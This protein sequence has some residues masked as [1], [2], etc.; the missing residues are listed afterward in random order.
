MGSVVKVSI[1]NTD[2]WAHYKYTTYGVY[3]AYKGFSVRFSANYNV[4]S[5]KLH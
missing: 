4:I 5:D 1:R 2:A 3:V